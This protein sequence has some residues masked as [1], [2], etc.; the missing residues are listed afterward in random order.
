MKN[1]FHFS[2][3][4]FHFSLPPT[5]HPVFYVIINKNVIRNQKDFLYLQS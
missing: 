3:F 2:F 5:L 4:I 1:E